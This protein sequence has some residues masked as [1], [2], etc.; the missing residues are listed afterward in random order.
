MSMLRRRNRNTTHSRRPLQTPELRLLLPLRVRGTLKQGQNESV[1]VK[2]HRCI[3]EVEDEAREVALD[4][5]IRL[6]ELRLEGA[7]GELERLRADGR[8]GQES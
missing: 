3:G 1:R 2:T 6:Q 4:T 5:L 7:G 8:D